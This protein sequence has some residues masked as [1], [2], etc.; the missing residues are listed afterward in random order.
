MILNSTPKGETLAA[1]SRSTPVIVDQI[2]SDQMP[3]PQKRRRRRRGKL[4]LEGFSRRRTGEDCVSLPG[5]GGDSDSSST[6]S[7]VD[8]ASPPPGLPD[9]SAISSP[10]NEPAIS[11][12]E[13][14]YHQFIVSRLALL[15]LP[16]DDP[17]SAH[18]PRIPSIEIIKALTRKSF[19]DDDARVALVEYQCQNFLDETKG[20]DIQL[21]DT[22][23]GE[24]D[25]ATCTEPDDDIPMD[26]YSGLCKK[27]G[28]RMAD[29]D[30]YTELNRERT[31]ELRRKHALYRIKT[32]LLLKG[33]PVEELDDDDALER[34]YPRDLIVENKYFLHYVYD[35][36]FGWY[37]D[38]DLCNKEFLTDYQRLVLSNDGGVE[39]IQY[40]SWSTYRKF[41]CT[42][43]ADRDYLKYWET[44]VKKMKWLENHA[45]K[46]ECS[47]EWS[48]IHS[49]ATFQALSIAAELPNMTLELAAL[50]LDEY[51]WNMRSNLP[52]L[53]DLDGI[54]YEI[55]SRMNKN[56]QLCFREALRKVYDDELFPANSWNM[57]T[58]LK[59]R[60]GLMEPL[61]GPCTKG[62]SEQLPK[63]RAKELIAQEIHWRR[64]LQGSYELYARKKLEIAELIGLIPKDKKAA[65]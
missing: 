22:D 30:T 26:E 46:K 8:G 9:E 55:W 10:S 25:S 33:M 49:K 24:S 39:C 28:D 18:L 36:Y 29:I 59:H 21:G 11:S 15:E 54:F 27:L 57:K 13:P 3:M 14:R 12:K 60:Y 50:G 44:L 2:R 51:I 43:Q 56:R 5:F 47:Y 35:G 6:S 31:M 38:S 63:H 23:S 4:L 19:Y 52:F 42:P 20:S 45:E 17:G 65:A 64:G 37:F 61:F 16:A 41:Y 58:E 62:L 40:A 34:K 48:V 32:A 53:K 7:P 1:E